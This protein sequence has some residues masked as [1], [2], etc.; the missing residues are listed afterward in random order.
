MKKWA[1]PIYA[2]FKATP[3][4][5]YKN[6][7]HMH[8]FECV[9]KTCRGRGTKKREVNRYVDTADSTSTSN[10]RKHA[11]VC[12]GDD[13]I[14]AADDTND[15]EAAC[16]IVGASGSSNG[17]IMASFKRIGKAK[18]TYSHKPHMKTETRYVSRSMCSSQD[19]CSVG[20]GT[21]LK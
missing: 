13:T 11:K 8:V 1:S 21:G 3:R 17:S 7:H 4:I 5:E 10:L 15:V 9:S 18:V 19:L 16:K 14:A 20:C 6:G 2:F 12:W